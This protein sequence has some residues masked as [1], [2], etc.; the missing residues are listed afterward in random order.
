MYEEYYRQILCIL[1]SYSTSQNLLCT[2][3]AQSLQVSC[4]QVEV[5]WNVGAL[6]DD[7]EQLGA[8]CGDSEQWG[9]ACDDSEQ[10]GAACDDSE[11]WGVA[12]DD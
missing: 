3:I 1:N 2:K 5:V 11:Q 12:C 7:S 10:L 6:C 8:A 9:A 4:A